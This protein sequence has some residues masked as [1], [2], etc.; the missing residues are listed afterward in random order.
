MNKLEQFQAA[1][2]ELMRDYGVRVAGNTQDFE[3]DVVVAANKL[4]L[5]EK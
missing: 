1:L 5:L 4:L 2:H 3:H